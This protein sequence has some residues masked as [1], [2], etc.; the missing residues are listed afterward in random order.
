MAFCTDSRRVCNSLFCRHGKLA[1]SPTAEICGS[2]VSRLASTL[3]PFSMS[4]PASVAS[5]ALGITP[6]PNTTRSAGSARP[7]PVCT[8][9]TL[10]LS[11]SMR[12]KP[13]RKSK[14]TPHASWAW[15]NNSDI[16]RDTARAMGRSPSSSTCTLAPRAAATA[17]NSRPINPAPITTTLRASFASG[18]RASAS[19]LVL[20][21][22][23]C[24]NSAPGT[25]RGRLWAPVASTRWS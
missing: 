20:I 13:W 2:E 9:H 1:T 3:M 10:P 24:G 6:I 12:L 22:N 5:C 21:P 7:S 11:P 19:A 4:R 8:A 18:A 16:S 25:G 15:R 14:W 17:A 23:T